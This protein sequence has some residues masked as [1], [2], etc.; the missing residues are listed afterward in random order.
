MAEYKN[1]FD[2]RGSMPVE[3]Q[4]TDI[5]IQSGRIFYVTI[6][7]ITKLTPRM[8]MKFINEGFMSVFKFVDIISQTTPD[9]IEIGSWTSLS[10]VP[11]TFARTDVGVSESYRY[12]LGCS[13]MVPFEA[14]GEDSYFAFPTNQPDGGDSGS[15][16]GGGR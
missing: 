15:G 16:G 11:A 9:N 2:Y 14:D 4:D 12:Q 13:S 6:D 3:R 7:N 5:D 10:F 1:G 8:V